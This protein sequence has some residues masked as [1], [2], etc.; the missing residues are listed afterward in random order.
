[1]LQ[2][3]LGK[4]RATLE[5]WRFREWFEQKLSK[6]DVSL[7]EVARRIGYEHNASRLSEYIKGKR[8]PGAAMVRQ[9]A[10]AIDASPIEALWLAGYHE[11]FF[12]ELGDLHRIGWMWCRI[13]RVDPEDSGVHFT[14]QT[15]PG[16]DPTAVPT[17]LIHRYHRATIYH[18]GDAERRIAAEFA[19]PWPLVLAIL[20]AIG[21]FPRRGDAL[22]PNHVERIAKL[23]SLAGPFIRAAKVLSMPPNYKESRMLRTAKS[24]S[25]LRYLGFSGTA[26]VAEY[27]NYWADGVC[28]S[29]AAYARLALFRRIGRLGVL[30]QPPHWLEDHK[31]ADFLTEDELTALT[32]A[33]T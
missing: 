20:I 13:D 9:L 7:R 16:G 18:A 22:R 19:L 12:D 11:A 4:G 33:I 29:Y 26:I 24:L 30:E 3:R 2:P 28:R 5:M 15:A 27:V 23:A 1:M 10:E 8:V 25:H 17:E 21:A 14:L 31:T 6:R 32:H